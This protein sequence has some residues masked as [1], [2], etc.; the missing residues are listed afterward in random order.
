MGYPKTP[1]LISS[2]SRR[3]G[4]WSLW[5]LNPALTQRKPQLKCGHNFHVATY[6][7]ANP[8]KIEMSNPTPI[9]RNSRWLFNLFGV[10]VS[11][12]PPFKSRPRVPFPQGRQLVIAMVDCQLWRPAAE[13]PMFDERW[14]MHLWSCLQL[15]MLCLY[16]PLH[17]ITL[18]VYMIV[19]NVI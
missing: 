7:V 13:V 16:N 5:V 2:C 9:V 15:Y 17:Y 1:W 8:K 11:I 19:C 18:H 12:A 6:T 10:L 4:P 14:R 3:V